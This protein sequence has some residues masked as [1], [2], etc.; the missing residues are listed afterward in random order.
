MGQNNA[1]LYSAIMMNCVLSVALEV[2]YVK[3]EVLYFVVENAI[4]RLK[5]TFLKE[6]SLQQI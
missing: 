4:L 5:V 3:S 1:V 2:L 6:N